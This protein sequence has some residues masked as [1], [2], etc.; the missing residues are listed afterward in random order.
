LKELEHL[1]DTAVDAQR[2]H[3]A[4]SYYSTS[5]TLNSPSPQGILIK[6]SKARMATGSWKQAVDDAN[7]VLYIVFISC[8]SILLTRYHQVIALDPLSPWGYEMKHAALHKAGDFHN[9]VDAIET[10]LSKIVQSPDPD[11]RRQLHSRYHDKEDSFT[12]LDRA[13]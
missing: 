10:M 7:Q 4:V 6:R 11:I 12:L 3:E 1:G 13:W 2:H 9:A 8:M 5:L